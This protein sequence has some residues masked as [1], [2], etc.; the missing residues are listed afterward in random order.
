MSAGSAASPAACAQ[1]NVYIVRCADGTLYTGIAKDLARRIGEHNGDHGTG[2]SYT[3]A[4]RPVA[5]VYQEPAMSR[6]AATRREAEIKQL[7]RAQK[8]TLIGQ[9]SEFAVAGLRAVTVPG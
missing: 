1:W 4:R 3:R 2:A 6:A 5:L 9:G 8:E 7:T